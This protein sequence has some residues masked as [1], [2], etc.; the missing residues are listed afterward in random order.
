[1]V[2]GNLWGPLHLAGGAKAHINTHDTMG[3]IVEKY[4]SVMKN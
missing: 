2:T 3:A 4:S 1:M